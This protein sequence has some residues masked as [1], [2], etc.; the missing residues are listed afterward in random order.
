M[1]DDTAIDLKSPGEFR[2]R[3]G[4]IWNSKLL[5][6]SFVRNYVAILYIVRD[7]KQGCRKGTW[8]LSS[9]LV[10]EKDWVPS[11]FY[12]VSPGQVN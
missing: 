12:D 5:S 11:I 7:L 2:Y 10:S 8:G 1:T 4:L 6:S 9:L 3:M